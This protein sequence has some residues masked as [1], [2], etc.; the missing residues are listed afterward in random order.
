MQE[1][2]NWTAKLIRL[3]RYETPGADYFERFIEE[4]HERQRAEPLQVSVGTLAADRFATWWG[5]VSTP[6][7]L[8]CASVAAMAVMAAAGVAWGILPS[9]PASQHPSPEGPTLA[10]VSLIREF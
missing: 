9:G 7:R 8:A 10:E 6:A 4:F 3:K 5:S 2:D 1:Q